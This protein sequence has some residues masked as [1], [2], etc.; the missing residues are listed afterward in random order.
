M[1]MLLQRYKLQLAP[2]QT[3]ANEFVLTMRPKYG[4]KVV[5]QRRETP[6]GTPK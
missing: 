3:D 1:A 2:G 5:L 6:L 4:M